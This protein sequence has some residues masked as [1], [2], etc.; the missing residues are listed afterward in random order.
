[1]TEPVDVVARVSDKYNTY[2]ARASGQSASCTSGA[3]HAA[4]ALARKVCPGA[5]AGAKVE[6][7]RREGNVEFWRIAQA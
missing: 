4:R 5:G 7:L 2:T 3:E 1:M 6:F